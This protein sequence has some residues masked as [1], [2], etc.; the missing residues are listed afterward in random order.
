MAI[1]LRKLKKPVKN[2]LIS[3]TDRIGDFMLTL[4]VFEALKKET[5]ARITVLCQT[6]VAPLLLNNPYVDQVITVDSGQMG[7]VLISKIRS[8]NF[9]SLLVLVND[10]VIRKLIPNLKFIPQRIGPASKLSMLFHYTHPVIQKRSRSIQNEAAYNLE[11]IELISGKKANPIPP[12]LYI[13]SKEKDQFQNA[14]PK[15]S[16]DLNQGKTIVLHSGMNNSA[17]NWSLECYQELLQ[18]LVKK[19]YR[20][21]LTGASDHES[22]TNQSLIDSLAKEDQSKAVN[23]SGKLNLR[24]LAVLFSMCDLFIGPSTGPTHVA[25]GAGIPVISF[26]PPIQVQSKKRWE[27]FLATSEIFVPDARCGQKYRC[28]GEK[29]SDFYCLDLI[30]P[31]A[32]EKAVLRLLKD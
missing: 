27:P 11:L 18:R 2:I 8:C 9:D 24:E 13:E 22:D 1:F 19:N 25:N 21:F 28:L 20:I 30:T 6:L 15:I 4:P 17:L 26:Y 29:C 14:F 7:E 10:P 31:E 16:D 3:R 12:Q 5:D 32:V 23:L